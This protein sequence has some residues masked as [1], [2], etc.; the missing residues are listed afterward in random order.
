[1]RYEGAWELK[2]P[3]LEHL[4]FFSANVIKIVFALFQ[5]S[6]VLR[7]FQLPNL[8]KVTAS[9]NVFAHSLVNFC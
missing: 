9:E 1:M 8:K 4:H 7:K 6:F 5:L 3:T 2:P